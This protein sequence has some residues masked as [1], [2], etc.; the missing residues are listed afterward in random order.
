MAEITRTNT[1]A[2]A[3]VTAAKRKITVTGLEALTIDESKQLRALLKEQEKVAATQSAEAFWI[4]FPS[5][6]YRL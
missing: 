1:K 2:V 4:D 6:S 5:Y 3:R